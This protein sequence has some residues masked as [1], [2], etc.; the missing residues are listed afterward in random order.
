[1]RPVTRTWLAC[2]FVIGHLTWAT[3][4]PCRVG[5]AEPD[6]NVVETFDVAR[7]GDVLLVPVELGNRQFQFVVDTGCTWC[8]VDSELES[9]LEPTADTAGINGRSGN[10]LYRLR[11]ASVGKSRLPL[12]GKALCFDLS[13]FRE[14]TGYDICGIV[15]M[16]FLKSRVIHIDF[17]A[18]ELAILK[19][20][21]PTAG[22]DFRLSYSSTQMPVVFVEIEPG[23]PIAFTI[24]TGKAGSA[25]ALRLFGFDRLA[26]NGRLEPIGRPGL[27]ATFEG[28]VT[29]REGRL[30]CFRLGKFEHE[31]ISVSEDRENLIGL[32]LLSRYVVTLDFPNDRLHLKPGKRCQERDQFGSCG[33]PIGRI[34]DKTRIKEVGDGSVGD[35]AGLKAGDEILRIDG[36]DA[37]SLTMFEM[38]KILI[39]GGRRVRLEVEGPDG[40]RE[41][42]LRVA[43]PVIE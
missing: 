9:L 24:D 41:V 2:F 33:I 37:A 35:K 31:D 3:A 11:D 12:T 43:G 8:V 7:H 40:R 27:Y 10:R 17:D 20:T 6:E 13:Q 15:G 16:S 18:G 39:T 25:L 34:E 26:A 21:P 30:K 5:A 4:L 32:G 22:S 29:M 23:K 28:N 19:K 14:A 36:R 42:E 1:M 38:R